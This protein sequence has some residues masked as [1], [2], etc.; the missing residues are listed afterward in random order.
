MKKEVFDVC[1]GLMAIS[2]FEEWFYNDAE[3]QCSILEDDN[4]LR[5]CSIDL[6]K[7]DAQ[8]EMNKFCFDTFD[9]EE[10]YVYVIEKNAGM[11]IETDNRDEIINHVRNICT[12]SGW[13]DSKHLFYALYFLEDQYN[14]FQYSGYATRGQ[15]V[16]EMK[17]HA[18]IIVEKFEKSTP[19]EKKNWVFDGF[20]RN[21]LILHT[22]TSIQVGV[23]ESVPQKRWY[24]FWKS[25]WFR[26]KLKHGVRLRSPLGENIEE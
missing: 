23:E 24:Q 21:N 10:F 22:V 12:Y 20:D 14:D 17:L 26:A 9:R 2:E 11:I 18:E 25:L 1:A 6:T 5:L 16:N 4:V 7:R 15:I 19:Q 8:Y 3:I 13:E